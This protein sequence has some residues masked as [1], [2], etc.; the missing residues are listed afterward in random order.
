MYQNRNNNYIPS[1]VAWAKAK[2]YKYI[3][4]ELLYFIANNVTAVD[5]YLCLV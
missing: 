2:N 5:L 3:M 4:Q 1:E